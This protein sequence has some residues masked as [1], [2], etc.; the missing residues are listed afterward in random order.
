VVVVVSFFP[1]PLPFPFRVGLPSLFSLPFRF[2]STASFHLSFPPAV[3]SILNTHISP[4]PNLPAVP[5][6]TSPLPPLVLVDSTRSLH[7]LSCAVCS[8]EKRFS[9]ASTSL[10][11]LVWSR[12]AEEDRE[13]YKLCDLHFLLLSVHYAAVSLS[14]LRRTRLHRL[15]LSIRELA[16][17]PG[18]FCERSFVLVSWPCLRSLS[19]RSGGGRCG[20]REEPAEGKVVDDC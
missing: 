11:C 19:G 5:V 2:H 16:F 17:G 20:G 12:K 18:A 13:S 3:P 9:F 10:R 6:H 15:Q 7:R 1:F 8:A 4:S 14:S